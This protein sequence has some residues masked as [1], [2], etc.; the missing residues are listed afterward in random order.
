VIEEV[1]NGRHPERLPEFWADATRTE[2]EQKAQ[3]LVRGVGEG[4]GPKCRPECHR[5]VPVFGGEL[6][7]PALMGV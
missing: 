2:A 1:W 4:A 5:N 7:V 6:I 3:A